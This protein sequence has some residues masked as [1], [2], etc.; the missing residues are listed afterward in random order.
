VFAF[1][2]AEK[3]SYPVSLMCQVLGVNRTSFHDWERR[4]PSDREL[5]DAFVL[6]RIKAIHAASRG[7]YG[8]PRVHASCAW[9]RGSRSARSG[10]SG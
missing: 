8:S 3:A 1:I 7:T 6:E 4:P 10:S 9:S 5:Y 2:A